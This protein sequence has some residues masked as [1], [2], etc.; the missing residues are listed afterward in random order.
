[1]RIR[2][3]ND[4]VNTRVWPP[5]FDANSEF[6]L[7]M[8]ASNENP[9][10]RRAT[11]W[12]P[13]ALN[14]DYRPPFAKTIRILRQNDQVNTRV[15]PPNF[16]ANQNFGVT[17]RRLMRILSSEWQLLW[18]PKALNDDFRP[19]FAKTMRILQQNDQVNTRVWPPNFDANS[20]FWLR[21]TV[22]NENPLLRIATFVVA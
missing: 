3:Q 1:M 9:S 16:D 21:M 5:N 8:T 13:T 10:L 7:P 14:D 22:I 18:S 12:S 2:L 11:F 15:W 17:W 4:Q 20:D 19:P 6:W